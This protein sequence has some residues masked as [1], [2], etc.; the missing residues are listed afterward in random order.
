MLSSVYYKVP[1]LFVKKIR[2]RINERL[3]QESE[4]N[5]SMAATTKSAKQEPLDY[6][7]SAGVKKSEYIKESVVSSTAYTADLLDLDLGSGAP[8]NGSK[9]TTTTSALEDLLGDM[10]SS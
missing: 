9:P 7:D 8:S 5:S 2:D 4:D 3:D 1:D 6:V 10:G